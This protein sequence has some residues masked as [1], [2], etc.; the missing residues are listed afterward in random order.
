VSHLDPVGYTYN[1]AA[2]HPECLPKGVDPDGEEVGAIFQWD[3][4]ACE[5]VC[6]VCFEPL[7]EGESNQ[8][9]DE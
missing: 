2:Y 8:Q 4:A 6:D 3:E 9:E 1:A 7:L 5:L